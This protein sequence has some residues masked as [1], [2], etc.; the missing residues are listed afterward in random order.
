MRSFLDAYLFKRYARIPKT[1]VPIDPS[2][3]A[4]A[5]I[6]ADGNSGSPTDAASKEKDKDKK[7]AAAL[8]TRTVGGTRV[9]ILFF[10]DPIKSFSLQTNF[11]AIGVDRTLEGLVRTKALRPAID[12]LLAK[13]VSFVV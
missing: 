13:G 8:T 2:S 1:V 6:G 11:T 5:L 4:A 10:T 3:A 9:R 7:A 12:S